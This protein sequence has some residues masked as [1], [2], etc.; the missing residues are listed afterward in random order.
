MVLFLWS[1]ECVMVCC[2]ACSKMLMFRLI[3]GHTEYGSVMV[4]L[5]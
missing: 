1:V 5:F 4:F 2:F 3:L